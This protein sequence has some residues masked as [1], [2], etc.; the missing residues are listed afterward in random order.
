MII[1]KITVGLL[2]LLGAILGGIE[3]IEPGKIEKLYQLGEMHA[4][5]STGLRSW[6]GSLDM[7]TLLAKDALFKLSNETFNTNFSTTSSVL[8]GGFSMGWDACTLPHLPISSNKSL[9][10]TVVGGSSTA[11]A[12]TSC[13]PTPNSLGSRYTNILAEELARDLNTSTVIQVV[14]L[15]HGATDSLWSSLTMDQVL[16]AKHCDVLVWEFATNDAL[17]GS[18]GHPKRSAPIL[19]QMLDLWLWRVHKHFSAAGRQPPPIVLLYLWDAPSA[20]GELGQSAF[21]AQST[22]AKHYRRAGLSISVVNV[23]GALSD[24]T[25]LDDGHHPGC[26]GVHLISAMIRHVLYSDIVNCPNKL[27]ASLSAKKEI[28]NLRPMTSLSGTGNRTSAVLNALLGEGTIGSLMEWTPQA[29]KSR[30]TLVS[31]EAVTETLGGA[32]ESIFRNDRKRSYAIFRCP[33]KANFTLLEPTLEW[34][35][36]GIGGGYYATHGYRGKVKVYI[37]GESANTTLPYLLEIDDEVSMTGKVTANF[38]THWIHVP[39][40]T[41]NADEYNVQVCYA[42]SELSRCPFYNASSVDEACHIWLS[43]Q[44]DSNVDCYFRNV[45]D[46]SDACR[47][48]YNSPEGVALQ[49]MHG[50]YV[51]AWGKGHPQLNWII[52]VKS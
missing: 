51:G 32:K 48:W 10:I 26:V 9:Q 2:I 28:E 13:E 25:L 34:L 23:G 16:D 3:L 11:R 40:V 18:T 41:I 30:L 35:G 47:T 1:Q 39:D 42:A 6:G 38:V 31:E 7:L 20:L 45:N 44:N 22:V 17:G 24:G 29:G 43:K 15:A 4:R 33:E 5:N 49:E 19:S 8:N 14:N 37:N 50:W 12:A 52:G 27:R 21:L 46:V 36:L